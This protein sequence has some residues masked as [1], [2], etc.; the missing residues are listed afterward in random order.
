MEGCDWDGIQKV[1][2]FN[3]LEKIKRKKYDNEQKKTDKGDQLP[4]RERRDKS[5]QEHE[6]LRQALNSKSKVIT[7][8][9]RSNCTAMDQ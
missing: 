8:E 6:I 4:M 1:K 3:S 2:K 9:K 7:V 5:L